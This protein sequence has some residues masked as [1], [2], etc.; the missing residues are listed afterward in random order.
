MDIELTNLS[1]KGQNNFIKYFL[2]TRSKTKYYIVI[3][4]A[5]II[6]ALIGSYIFFSEHNL[7]NFVNYLF[8]NVPLYFFFIWSMAFWFQKDNIRGMKKFIHEN[9]NNGIFHYCFECDKKVDT[10]SENCPECHNSLRLNI[11]Q[12]NVK[13]LRNHMQNNMIYMFV[14]A[15]VLFTFIP[16]SI[17]TSNINSLKQSIYRVTYDKA[18]LSAEAAFNTNQMF[19]F[20]PQKF[21][22]S[23]LSGKVMKFHNNIPVCSYVYD[24]HDFMPFV[25][26]RYHSSEYASK[27]FCNAFNNAMEDMLEQKTNDERHLKAQQ[28]LSSQ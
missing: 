21:S 14:V 20:A 12:S 8:I 1:K 28:L 5:T 27:V 25:Y 11:F 16:L 10:N 4:I 17:M 9:S 22:G 18:V 24:E 3:L 7:T 19:F 6:S 26:I 13:S 2:Q 15:L 23:N